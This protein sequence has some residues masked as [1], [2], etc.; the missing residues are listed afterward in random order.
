MSRM[1]PSGSVEVTVFTFKEGLLSR[2]AHDLKLSVGQISVLVDGS[3]VSARIGAGSLRVVCAMKRGREDHRALKPKD[4]AEIERLVSDEVLRAGRR[5]EILFEGRDEGGALAG[6]LTL[7]GQARPIRAIWR[8]EGDRRIAEVELD[9]R[10]FGITPY[11][12]MM[13]ALKV[14]PVVR[15]RIAASA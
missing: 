3:A 15:V 9:Q 7:G 13:G 2:A 10:D 4:R 6:I 5:A 8:Q 1:I 12:A 11:Q 14:Q